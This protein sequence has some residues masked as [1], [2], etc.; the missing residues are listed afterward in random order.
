MSTY[1][2][3]IELSPHYESVVD[4]DSEKRNPN[5]WRE[6]IVHDDMVRTIDKI[7]ES[8]KC[9]NEDARRSFWIHGAYGTGKTYSALVLQHLFEDSL[10]NVE[11]FFSDNTSLFKYR[12]SFLS[13]REKGPF[14]VVWR[15]GCTGI[16]TGIQL[17]MVMESAIKESLKQTFGDKAYYGKE[18][19]RDVIHEKIRDKSIH[20][21][22]IFQSPDYGLSESYGSFEEFQ[23]EVFLDVP[24]AVQV[25]TDIIQEKG[26]AFFNTVKQFKAWI[27]DVIEGNHLE[28]T[29]I[30]FLWDEFSGFLR[31]CGDD[32]VLQELSQYCKQQPFFLF[33]IVHRDPGWIDNLG[34]E[35]YQRILHRYHELEFRISEDAAYDLI[36]NTIRPCPGME[37]QWKAVQKK[38]NNALTPYLAD[39]ENASMNKRESALARLSPLH[40]MTLV[41]LTLVAQNFGASQRTLFRFMKDPADAGRKVGFLHFISHYGPDDWS[42]VTPDFLWD[43]FFS[44]GSDTKNFNEEVRSCYHHFEESWRFLDSDELALHVF[45]AVMLLIALMSTTRVTHL[46]SDNKKRPFAATKKSLYKCFAGH[47]NEKNIDKLLDSFQEMN[48]LGLDEMRNGEIRLELPYKGNRNLFDNTFKE[49]KERYTRY[50]LFMKKGELSAFLEERGFLWDKEDATYKRVR[51]M[52]CSSEKKSWSAREKDLLE[53][54]DKNPYKIGLLVVVPSKP[55]EYVSLQKDFRT[56]AE[57]N[58]HEKLVYCLLQ[59]PLTEEALDLWWRAITR[60]EL[61]S[62]DAKRASATQHKEEARNIF[63]EWAAEAESGKITAFYKG[64]VFSALSGR[65]ELSRKIKEKALFVLFPGAPERVVQT[66]TAFK[67]ASEKAALAGIK[68]ES[69][70]TQFKN[71]LESLERAKVLRCDSLS[72]LACCEGSFATEAVASL[73]KYMEKKLSSGTKI[74][75]DLLWEDLQKP[76]FGYYDCHAC[77]AMLGLVFRFS[78]NSQ[79]NWVDDAQ[80]SHAPTEQN[81]ATMIRDMCKD[82]VGSHTF[83]PGSAAWMNFREYVREIFG[84]SDEESTG[85]DQARKYI[86]ERINKAGIPFWALKYLDENTFGGVDF[87]KSASAIVDSIL[88]FEKFPENAES[89]M[90]ETLERFKGKGKLR[91]IITKA[92]GDV[93]LLHK[94]FRN[95]AMVSNEEAAFFTESPN[96][97]SGDLLDSVTKKM[98]GAVYT[99]DEKSVEI[100]LREVFWEY[101][102]THTINQVLGEKSP[103]KIVNLQENLASY[104]KNM[105]IPGAVIEDLQKPWIKGLRVL[106]SISEGSIPSRDGVLESFASF[107]DFQETVGEA[108]ES[109][110]ASKILLRE[111]LKQKEIFFSEEELETLFEDLASVPYESPKALFE[112]SVKV[113]LVNMEAARSRKKL[114]SLWKSHTN[115]DSIS[116]WCRKHKIPI[117]WMVPKDL[118]N[119]FLTLKLLQEGT[120]PEFR[121]LEKTLAFFQEY[122]FSKIQDPAYQEKCFFEKIGSEHQQIFVK[123][124][125]E[126][127]AKILL[128]CGAEVYDWEHDAHRIATLVESFVQNLAK[129]EFLPQAQERVR[130]MKSSLLRARVEE[131]LSKQPELS[132]FFLD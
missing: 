68:G 30:V 9:E 25:V 94:G 90:D 126:I 84:L 123:K 47:L 78:V 52:P 24:K 118:Q 66:N 23:K 29:G 109:V 53:E 34:E 17:M 108:W 50:N 56:L 88:S 71:I 45:K 6:Y 119:H 13:I 87:K 22:H 111:Y 101:K 85:E 93:T 79:H 113:K 18:S 2:K 117:Q 32:N 91:Q 62:G 96:I 55:Q 110:K 54:L 128:E 121:E 114:L 75:L 19:L 28:E 74:R 100:V 44:S 76:P 60:Q 38:L 115:T 69:D 89:H 31:D 124:K 81:L 57:K 92:F 122:D 5:L 40:P 80:N 51:I 130:S 15:S 61:A 72:H 12:N 129:E 82:K 10:E 14:L 41:L 1:S 8:L 104:F 59:K 16:K 4:K 7:C 107:E 132:R 105:K 106:V 26:W 49:I 112:D 33:L 98:Q 64:M 97:T 39:F 42:W 48:I 99:W 83:S 36:G 86:R 46:S 125:E 127:I 70:N 3:Y 73:G 43:Y 20:W 35:T 27:K 65:D 131:L 120:L 95:F 103:K 116:L 11:V 21:G 63:T 102:L 37:D 77:A 67:L 58:L